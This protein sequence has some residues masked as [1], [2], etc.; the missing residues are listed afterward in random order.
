MC[1]DMHLCKTNRDKLIKYL[2]NLLPKDN[3]VP[4]S[5]KSLI[6]TFTKNDKTRHQF[7]MCPICCTQCLKKSKKCSNVNC[8]TNMQLTKQVVF[9]YCDVVL[10]DIEGQLKRIILKNTYSTYSTL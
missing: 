10:F 5:Y 8:T 7:K 4:A 9:K 2:G 1:N 3:K 6:K